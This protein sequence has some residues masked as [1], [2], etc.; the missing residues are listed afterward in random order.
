[1]SSVYSVLNSILPIKKKMGS[2]EEAESSAQAVPNNAYDSL[3]EL[4]G[5][6]ETKKAYSSLI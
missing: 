1:M 4:V 2:A 3:V 5:E 6:D